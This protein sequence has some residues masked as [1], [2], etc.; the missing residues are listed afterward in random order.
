MRKV[1]LQMQ[2]SIDGFVAGP[3][4]EM[5]WI[6][7]PWTEDINQYVDQ[8]MGNIDTIMLGRKL[9]EGFIPHWAGVA[10][11]PDNPEYISGQQFTDTPKVVFSKTL[12]K[13]EW[14]NTVLV[15]GN[16]VDEIAKLKQQ[17]G[18]DI[19]VYGGA[20][21]VSNLI[22]LNLIDTYYLFVNPVALG[23][24]MTIFGAVETKRH[25]KLVE[26]QTFDCGIVLL[27]YEK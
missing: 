10:A 21:F 16:V 2:L 13:V 14:N 6:T 7:L 17:N 24:G 9:A 4:G 1:K 22:S 15:K 20:N 19:F 26:I 27:N 5:D 12:N 18:K 11:D 23:K 3:N 25:L 8:I